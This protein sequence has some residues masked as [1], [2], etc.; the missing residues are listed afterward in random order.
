MEPKEMKFGGL[1]ERYFLDVRGGI[2]AIRDRKHPDYDSDYPG[3]HSYMGDVVCCLTGHWNGSEWTL[4]DYSHLEKMCN[5]L[6]QLWFN[7][8]G[9]IDEVNRINSIEIKKSALLDDYMED[10]RL[11]SKSTREWFYENAVKYVEDLNKITN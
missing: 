9:G 11:T 6:N 4:P 2:V 3:L 1:V 5:D 8:Q 10:W 7:N